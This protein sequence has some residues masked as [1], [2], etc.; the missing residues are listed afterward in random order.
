MSYLEVEQSILSKLNL[1]SEYADLGVPLTNPDSSGWA[2][3]IDYDSQVVNMHSGVFFEH[4]DQEGV[5]FFTFAAEHGS[6]SSRK[7]AVAYYAKKVGVELPS[8]KNPISALEPVADPNN[9][10]LKSWCRRKGIDPQI[11]IRE[12]AFVCT[13]TEQHN[14]KAEVLAIPVYNDTDRDKPCGYVTSLIG[15]DKT[16]PKLTAGSEKGIIGKHAYDRVT[17]A[18]GNPIPQ[19][20]IKCEGLTDFLR[21][22][23]EIPEQVRNSVFAFTNA[24]GCG[25][26]PPSWITLSLSASTILV[27]G[28]ADA[29]GQ[30]GASKWA[31]AFSQVRD[32][33]KEVHNLSLP[34]DTQEK[35]G[36]DVCDFFTD[37]HTFQDFINLQKLDIVDPRTLIEPVDQDAFA[38]YTAVYNPDTEK[39]EKTAKPVCEI[40]TDLVART[41]GWPKV[42]QGV[43]FFVED[44]QIVQSPNV[45][46][47]FGQLHQMLGGVDWVSG[48]SFITKR[49]FFQRLH[50]AAE[51]YDS[52]E[53]IPHVPEIPNVY[54]LNRELTCGDGTTLNKLLDFFSLANVEIDRELLRAAFMTPLWG[55]EPGTRPAFFFSSED[56]PGAGKTKA[57]ESIG[58]LYGG[59]VSLEKTSSIT[60]I[61][62]R[63]LSEQ[64]LGKRIALLDNVRAANWSWS[65]F[66]AL[67]SARTISGKRL[68]KGEG[69]RPNYLTYLLTGNGLS[70]NR[71][72]SERIVEIRMKKPEYA[73]HRNW[74]ADLY[75][76]I[77]RNRLAI[78]GDLAALLASDPQDMGDGASRWSGWEE[79]VLAKCANPQ[80][81]FITIQKRKSEAYAGSDTAANM[82]QILIQKLDWYNYDPMKDRVF[83]PSY[84]INEWY[85]TVTKKGMDVA[86]SSR[87]LQEM[88]NQNELPNLSYHPTNKCKGF[89][90]EGDGGD[91][92]QQIMMDLATKWDAEKHRKEHGW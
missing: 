64:A 82:H 42:S 88:I 27:V 60:E 79:S 58:Y 51:Q 76:F 35:S 41:D 15:A 91:S 55:G 80:K 26:N 3:R 63:L 14:V 81:L 1:C 59:A 86:W 39:F 73:E 48:S 6:F 47:L 44:N 53:V 57:A 77:E 10:K 19:I 21:L 8:R 33:E 71:D 23:S 92:E 78:L 22:A 5:N 40:I 20:A 54:Y 56:G 61:K 2:R 13:R 25:E 11:A 4:K 69:S 32:G 29:P 85:T 17:M 74:V 52:I 38:N 36:K 45:D 28:D 66:E 50:T 70:L 49:E 37:D 84:I 87:M 46:H 83:I 34:Y 90:W 18:R 16:N 72:I 12:G 31:Y 43:L 9:E 7:D 67:L 65:D 89:V 68:Y 75:Q 24:H 30:R 62:T